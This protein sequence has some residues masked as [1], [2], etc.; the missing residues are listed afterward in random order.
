MKN[1]MLSRRKLDI[2]TKIRRIAFKQSLS[3]GEALKLF[4]ETEQI[5]NLQVFQING[6]EMIVDPR[7]E[8]TGNFQYNVYPISNNNSDYCYVC[9]VCGMIH[10]RNR[11]QANRNWNEMF[12]HDYFIPPCAD[13][14]MELDLLPESEEGEYPNFIHI[15]DN[16]INTILLPCQETNSSPEFYGW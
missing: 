1:G 11:G 16:G 10:R 15:I 13:S 9:P 7:T 14:E 4:P 6:K 8:T 2:L 3:L 12:F 5:R